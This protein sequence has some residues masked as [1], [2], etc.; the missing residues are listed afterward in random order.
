MSCLNFTGLEPEGN[1]TQDEPVLSL[2]HFT[3][4]K[5][6]DFWVY[7]KMNENIVIY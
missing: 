6:L 2:T 3:L 7:A 1:L 5:T 4:D